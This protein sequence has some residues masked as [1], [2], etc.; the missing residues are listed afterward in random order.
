MLKTNKNVKNLPALWV[1]V[2]E[3]AETDCVWCGKAWVLFGIPWLAVE[4]VRRYY[5]IGPFWF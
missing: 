1:F 5:H 2:S 3:L 4:Q